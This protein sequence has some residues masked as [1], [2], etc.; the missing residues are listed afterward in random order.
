LKRILLINKK[1]GFP[2]M[3]GLLDCMHWSWKNC[4]AAWKGQYQG[5]EKVSSLTIHIIYFH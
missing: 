4:P 1:Q 3:L 2:G 5:K